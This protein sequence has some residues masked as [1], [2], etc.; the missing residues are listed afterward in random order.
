MK[1]FQRY[2]QPDRNN[3]DNNS[4]A[5]QSVMGHMATQEYFYLNEF[6]FFQIFSIRS[7]SACANIFGKSQQFC[8]FV[9]SFSSERNDRSNYLFGCIKFNK[10][11]TSKV[12]LRKSLWLSSFRRKWRQDTSACLFQDYESG[13]SR[14]RRGWGVIFEKSPTK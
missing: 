11:D 6:V 3:L 1:S 14:S 2:P 13:R 8:L 9:R 4:I 12:E 10:I 5:V 7:E